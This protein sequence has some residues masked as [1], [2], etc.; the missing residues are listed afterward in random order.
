MRLRTR[1]GK[2]V[3]NEFEVRAAPSLIDDDDIKWIEVDV[4]AE[5]KERA[6]YPWDESKPFRFLSMD[7]D[8]NCLYRCIATVVYYDKNQFAKVRHEMMT[9][10]AKAAITKWARVFGDTPEEIKKFVGI[11]RIDGEWATA[12]VLGLAARK[13]KMNFVLYDPETRPYFTNYSANFGKI[14]TPLRKK[15]ITAMIRYSGSHFD[16][17]RPN[18]EWLKSEEYLFTEMHNVPVHIGLR[19]K[20]SSP[21]QLEDSD[22]IEVDVPAGPKVRTTYPWDE[23]KPSGSSFMRITGDGNCLYRCIA[24]IVYKDQKQH[25]K[26]RDELMTFLAKSA[27]TKWARVF[28]DTPEEIKKFVEIH[29]IDGEWAKATVLGLAARKYRMNFVLY[30][31]DASPYFTNYSANFGKIGT[32]LRKNAITAMIRY[33]GSHFDVVR[34]NVECCFKYRLEQLE[35]EKNFLLGHWETAV[36]TRCLTRRQPGARQS[37]LGE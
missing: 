21:D 37:V 7:G 14:G 22:I 4:P 20:S 32:P 3:V 12:T 13:Y 10:L 34:P 8:G 28:G 25:A 33:S 11:H 31:P 9:F 6:L 18:V 5:T 29:S 23:S 36:E 19:A 1:R 16:V 30:D 2:T 26:V 17:V 27:K 24:K 15:A 35:S